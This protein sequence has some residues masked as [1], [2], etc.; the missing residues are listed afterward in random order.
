VFGSAH[1]RPAELAGTDHD[2]HDPHLRSDVDYTQISRDPAAITRDSGDLSSSVC[3]PLTL[4]ANLMSHKQV[5]RNLTSVGPIFQ[6]QLKTSP[7]R[8]AHRWQ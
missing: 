2:G 6:R 7:G 4:S 1:T 8:N 5:P 3:V